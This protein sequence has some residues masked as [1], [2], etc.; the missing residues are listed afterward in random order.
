L[1]GFCLVGF[2]LVGIDW[3]KIRPIWS[4][5]CRVA[6]FGEFSSTRI[7]FGRIL[8]GRISFGRDRLGENSPNLVTLLQGGQIRRIF[9]Y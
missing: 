9:V 3:A 4:H 7:L 8:F 6:R 2:R 5:C 1:V